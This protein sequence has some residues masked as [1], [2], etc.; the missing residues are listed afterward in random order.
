MKCFSFSACVLM[1]CHSQPAPNVS[2]MTA[3]VSP[4]RSDTVKTEIATLGAGCFWCVEAV[5]EELRGVLQVESGYSGGSVPNPGYR[6]VCSGTTG[7]AEV[8]QVHFDPAQISYAEI[9]EVFWM[10]HDPTTLNR[11]GADAGTQYRSSIFYHSDEQRRIAEQSKAQVAPELWDDPIVTE[12]TP[13]DRF[14]PAE[15]YHQDYYRLNRAEPY[16]VM[17]IAP[18]LKKFRSRFADKRK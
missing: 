13:F 1:A 8:C 2:T 11:Q 9:L 14:Y 18:K 15:D 10:T 3:T 4:S 17:V 5:F 7:H 16:C 12:I 6:E